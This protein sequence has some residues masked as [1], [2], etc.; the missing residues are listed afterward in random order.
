[1]PI[2]ADVKADNAVYSLPEFNAEKEALVRAPVKPGQSRREFIRLALVVAGGIGLAFSDWM[3]SPWLR[4][5]GASPYEYWQ[6]CGP[7]PD[8]WYDPNTIC[9]PPDAYISSSTAASG[10][11]GYLGIFH[12][13]NVTHYWS[14]GGIS[15]K[16]YYTHNGYSCSNRN[17]WIWNGAHGV[18][19]SD[20]H[21][22]RHRLTLSGWVPDYANF[23]ICKS[24]V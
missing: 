5:A 23:S 11:C 17:A 16:G 13:D 10:N 1:M 3:A 18:M 4:R 19:C 2:D 22:T 21:K 24:N 9:Y 8:N 14:S 12:K 7:A 15:Y 20:G 6:H